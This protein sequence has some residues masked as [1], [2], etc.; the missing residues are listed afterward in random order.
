MEQKK[1]LQS[2]GRREGLVIFGVILFVIFLMH[3]HSDNANI[4]N[5]EETTETASTTSQAATQQV[6]DISAK[7][8]YKE[9]EANEVAADQKYKGKTVRPYGTIT[10]IGKD[11]T[12]DPYIVLDGPYLDGVQIVIKNPDLVASLHKG[13]QY[14]YTGTCEGKMGNVQITGL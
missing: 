13:Q 11:I 4:S 12:G 9:Y 5:R 3:T 6:I 8:L 14:A 10:S 7:Q 2:F 1:K